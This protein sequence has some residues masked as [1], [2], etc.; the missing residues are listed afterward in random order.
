MIG[1]TEISANRPRSV[2]AAA[3][4]RTVIM[5]APDPRPS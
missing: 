5:R 4:S 2:Y 3:L 1:T